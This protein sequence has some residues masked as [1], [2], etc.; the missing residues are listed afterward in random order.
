MLAPVI[1]ILPLTTIQRERLLP[2]AGRV[3]VRMDQKVSPVDVV[4]ETN[5]GRHHTLVDVA[6]LLGIS[7]IKAD[8]LIRC[9]AGE[10]LI[11]NQLIAVM[12]GLMSHP[13]Y[14]PC[15]GR[16]VAVGDGQVLMEVGD[17][18]F[19]LSAGLPGTISRVFPDRGVEI[20]AHGTLI[21]GVWG[22]SRVDI[23][24]M[25]PIPQ[26]NSSADPLEAGHLDI[27]LRGAI[28]IAGHCSDPNA[29]QVAGE[30]PLRGLILGSI[31][32][33]LLPLARKSRFP[34]V[35]TDGFGHHPMNAVAYKLLIT[36][37]KREVTLNSASYERYTGVRPEIFIPLPV[38]QPPPQARDTD[39]FSNGQQVRIRRN[40]NIFE[41]GTLTNLLSGVTE[42]PSGLSLPAADV[43]LESGQRVVV[44]LVNLE[45]LG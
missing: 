37:T 4:A 17:T 3:T 35:V 8:E 14:S 23:G 9:K 6:R 27:S 40:P 44:P 24:L 1:H 32:P 25:L 2:S 45:V 38:S 22:N 31:S 20:T 39:V 21:Q 19:E 34:I 15:D 36:N 16:V 26:L 18:I 30:L 10:R 12:P 33:D 43:L 29:L 13:V 41:V 11:S 7:P 42:F 28:L 5:L